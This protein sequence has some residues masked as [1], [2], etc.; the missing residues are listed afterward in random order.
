MGVSFPEFPLIDLVCSASPLAL[1]LRPRSLDLNPT[2]R[3]TRSQSDLAAAP[4]NLCTFQLLPS[5][6][7]A[8]DSFAL[9]ARLRPS[10]CS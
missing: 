7:L 4:D 2:L 5:K 3:P 8:R 9:E 6:S 10:P 1:E